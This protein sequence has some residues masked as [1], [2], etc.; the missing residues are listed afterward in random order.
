MAKSAISHEFDALIRFTNDEV[1]PDGYIK[2]GGR[3]GG[4]RRKK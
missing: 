4:H 3:E 2:R 1:I